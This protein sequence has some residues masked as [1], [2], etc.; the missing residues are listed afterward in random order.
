[1][2]TTTN[3]LDTL[4]GAVRG[5]VVTRGDPSYDE[6]R[7]V[8]NALHD[9]RPAVV[10]HAVDA[11]DVMA[12][13]RYAREHELPLAVRGGSHSVAGFGTVDDGLVVDLS[14][15]RGVRVDPAA[16]TARAEGGAT[17]GDFNHAT[18]AF[19]LATTGGVVSTTGIGGLT[20]G[21]GMGHLARRYGLSCDNL[22]AA[23]VVTAEGAL[24]SC[25]TERNPDLFWALRGG[26]GNFGV[27]VSLAYRLHPVTDVFGGLSCYPLDGG[28]ARAWQEMIT[29]APWE[30]NSILVLA[31]GPEEPFLPE[32]WHGRPLCAAFTCFS[33]PEAEDEKVLARLD[34]LGPVIGRFMQRMPYPVINTL[35]DEQL[36]PGLYH[37]WKGNFSRGL[38]DGAIAAHT[39]Y[40][41]TM[42]SLESDTAIFPIDG[43]CHRMGPEDTAFA[44]RDADFSHSFGGTWTDPADSDDNIAWT[45]AYDTALRPHTQEG[46]YVNFMDT[47][48]QD[49]VRVNYRQNYDRLRTVK[50]AYDPD[51]VFRLNQNIEP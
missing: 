43:A 19:G 45:R 14:R 9:R 28:V 33:G 17:W 25:D 47:D 10:V 24:V 26:G 42:P 21:G 32:R 31:L 49:R 20:L 38:S 46:G 50:R 3:P 16:R 48:D 18:H 13:V 15:M 22:I 29:V 4:R 41:A 39:E 37:Y 12:A 36:P 44:Y 35:F 51:N 34:G 8:Y 1:M 27:A 30:L 23:D 7:R 5:T 2:T 11:G 6:S 40:G